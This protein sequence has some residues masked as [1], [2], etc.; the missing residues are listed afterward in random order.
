M[1]SVNFLQRPTCYASKTGL[2]VV[3][4]GGRSA[5]KAGSRE[6]ATTRLFGVFIR[7]DASLPGGF[8]GFY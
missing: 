2:S 3:E 8:W 5:G 1:M 4:T 6:G 7:I